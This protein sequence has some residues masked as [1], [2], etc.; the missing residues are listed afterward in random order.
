MKTW[1]EKVLIVVLWL[2]IFP[3]M[4][5]GGL[6]FV[7]LMFDGFTEYKTEHDRCLKAAVNGYEIKRCH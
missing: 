5:I 1:S 4:C 7:G 6:M 3:A 2:F